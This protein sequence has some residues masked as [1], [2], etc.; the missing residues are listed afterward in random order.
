MTFIGVSEYLEDLVT[1]IDAPL[2]LHLYIT[3][4]HQLI[5][6]T[7][8]LAQ[9]LGR[10]PN[11]KAYNEARVIFSYSHATITLPRRVHPGLKL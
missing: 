9:F 3:F 4:F 5:F 1:R 7:P 6:D 2:L 8:Q 11:L 10:T